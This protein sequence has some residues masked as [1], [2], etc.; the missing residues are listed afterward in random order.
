MS[1]GPIIRA[2]FKSNGGIPVRFQAIEAVLPSQVITNE[3]IIERVK[4]ASQKGLSPA[5]LASLER[6]VRALF[7]MAKTETRYHRAP[8]QTALELGVSAGRAALKRAGVDPRDIDLFIYVGVARGYLEPA[9]A[10]VYQQH[11]GLVNAT[12]FDLLDACASWLRAVQVA[13]TFMEAGTYRTILILNSECNTREFG[14]PRF[15][16]LA[17]LENR[18]S[19]LTIGE[20]ATAT[21]LS[22]SNGTDDQFHVSFRNWGADHG[23]CKI[24][25]P[26]HHE[27]DNGDDTW[28]ITPLQFFARGERLFRSAFTK[29]IHHYRE[30]EVIRKFRPEISFSHAASDAMTERLGKR[31]KVGPAYL[32]HRRFGNTVSASI[33]LGMAFAIREGKLLSNMKVLLG[34]GSAG[35]TTGWACFRYTD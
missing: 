12:C 17:D 23:L 24:P 14:N 5:D 26:H 4:G 11:L 19:G 13:R 25:L 2:Q 18:F 22:P 21:I 31:L 20:A 29:M 15:T 35:I 30:D 33:P 6:R 9:T 10:N 3:D 8:G 32:T 16:S 7:A 1:I 34:C 28:P 27:Y